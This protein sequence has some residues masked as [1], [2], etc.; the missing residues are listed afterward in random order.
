LLAL[1]AVLAGVPISTGLVR[2]PRPRAPARASGA[3]VPVAGGTPSTIGAP[4]T[5][6]TMPGHPDAAA[7]GSVASAFTSAAHD[8]ATAW[9]LVLA[10]TD[11]AAPT[12]DPSAAQAFVDAVRAALEDDL[13]PLISACALDGSDGDPAAMVDRLDSTLRRLDAL[14]IAARSLI[15]FDAKEFDDAMA[16]VS[17]QLAVQATATL[18]FWAAAADERARTGTEGLAVTVHELRR[19]MTVLSSYAQLLAAGTLGELSEQIAGPVNSMLAASEV[20]LRLVESLAAIGRLE[21]P[22][23]PSHMAD[24]NVRETIERAV[25]EV[26]TEAGLRDIAIEVH[27]EPELRMRAD[28]ERLT[29]ALTN[30]LSNAVKHSRDGQRVE[31]R[32]LLEDD[33]VVLRVRDRGPGFSE[34]TAERLFEKYYRGTDE[35][36]RGVPGTGLGLYIVQTVAERH[37]GRAL[38]RPAAGGGAEFE[39]VLPLR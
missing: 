14:R 31:V 23:E 1:L 9:P 13:A 21:D 24:I 5:R 36:S 22:T 12:M 25:F 6:A 38:A 37:G 26:S 15:E 16:V 30:L 34:G 10:A 27:A 11:P 33:S 29:L 2:L 28:R 32:A 8:L 7:A 19:P 35:R 20:M 18:A 4:Y 39:L 3:G 17:R